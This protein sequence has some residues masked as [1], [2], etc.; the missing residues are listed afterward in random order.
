MLLNG[1]HDGELTWGKKNDKNT[2][3]TPIVKHRFFTFR[4]N[5]ALPIDFLNLA[6]IWLR[7]YLDVFISNDTK[8]KFFSILDGDVEEW[9]QV[10]D[11]SVGKV[12][13]AA[14]FSC[15]RSFADSSYVH[16]DQMFALR[17]KQGR[18]KQN[19]LEENIGNLYGGP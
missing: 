6:C 13:Q 3:V 15:L 16:G 7:E 14:V 4:L 19:A 9:S 10:F 12:C 8:C 1:D 18:M 17:R 5:G 11:E 2:N